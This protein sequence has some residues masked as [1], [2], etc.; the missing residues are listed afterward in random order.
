MKKRKLKKWVKIV[1]IIVVVKALVSIIAITIDNYKNDLK[2]C[3]TEKG[4][5]CNIFGK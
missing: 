5:T 1:L 2:K 3:D 4:Y